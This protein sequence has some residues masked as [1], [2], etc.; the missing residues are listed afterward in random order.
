MADL[1]RVDADFLLRVLPLEDGLLR[2]AGGELEGPFRRRIVGGQQDAAVGFDGE[3][4][5]AGCQV[6][7]VGHAVDDQMDVQ[8]RRRYPS[9]EEEHYG[10]HFTSARG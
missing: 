1:Q 9:R 2:G 4:P 5:V 6:E 3:H 8:G 7:P 10:Q